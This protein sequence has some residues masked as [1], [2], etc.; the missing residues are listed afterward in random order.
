MSALG[1]ACTSTDHVPWSRP[2][3]SRSWPTQVGLTTSASSS[4]SGGVARRRVAARAN[5]SSG[6]PKKS[7]IVCGA[8]IAV[9]AVALMNQWAEIA[10]MARGVGTPAPN[11]AHASV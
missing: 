3:L 9:T 2:Q 5:S 8:A 10:T 1:K 11:A 7:W 4:A 6:K